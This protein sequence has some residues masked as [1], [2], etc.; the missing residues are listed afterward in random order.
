MPAKRTSSR[1]TNRRA[2]PLSNRVGFNWNSGTRKNG[3]RQK[4]IKHK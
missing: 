1:N 4:T 2:Q 3:G